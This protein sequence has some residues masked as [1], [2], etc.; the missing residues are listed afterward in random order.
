MTADSLAKDH[1]WW[2]GPE[3]LS[4]PEE[5]W[6]TMCL[7]GIDTDDV[8]RKKKHRVTFFASTEREMS[9]PKWKWKGTSL[10]PERFSDWFK[11]LRVLA[12][13]I[14]FIQNC[15][16]MA[17][18]RGPLTVEEI[19]DA[20]IMVLRQAQQES[21]SD[22]LSRVQKGEALSTSSKISP[23]SPRFGSDG[24]LR[25]NSR[26]WLADHIAWEA[27]H[28]VI[29]TRKHPVGKLIVKRLQKDSNHSGTN[30]VLASLSAKFWL[31]GAREE[32]RDCERACMVC[33]RRKAQPASQIMAPL[34]AVRTQMSLRAFANISVDFAGPFLTK[35]GRGKTRFKRYLR[36]FACTNTR[37]VH[38]EMAIGLDTD[39]FLN[40]FYRITSRRGFPTQVISD[41]GM[42]FVGAAR[43]L[44][45][46]VNALDKTKI[47]ESTVKKRSG[48][49]IQPASST[50]LQWI[51]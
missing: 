45:E 51:T 10:D 31:L 4:Q 12:Q 44:R 32:I 18:V 35:Q 3:Y 20:E 50:T 13:V 41:N 40:A 22:E 8:E 49:E 14:R 28:P 27:R 5:T 26:L 23:I 33:K 29:L 21:Y 47:Q 37:A 19:N 1:T 30:Q 43:E 7:P 48:L 42:N 11:Y 34:P 39:S 9:Q 38:L 46:L 15:S 24:L 16:K 36:L 6:P 2:K 25:G 17:K